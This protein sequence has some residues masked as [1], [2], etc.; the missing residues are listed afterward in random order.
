M[1]Y[2]INEAMTTCTSFQAY[3]PT[4]HGAANDRAERGQEGR[5]Q[6]LK[7]EGNIAPQSFDEVRSLQCTNSR[8]LL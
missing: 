4:L 8:A 6:K 1:R 7:V 5:I 3:P 2:E